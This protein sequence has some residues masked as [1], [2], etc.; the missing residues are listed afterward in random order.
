M[1][2]LSLDAGF[3]Q[4]IRQKR[5]AALIGINDLFRSVTVENLEEAIL[6]QLAAAAAEIK[7]FYSSSQTDQRIID[8]A[9]QQLINSAQTLL[10]SGTHKGSIRSIQTQINLLSSILTRILTQELESNVVTL[11][12]RGNNVSGQE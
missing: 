1:L 12:M 4:T 2:R 5:I 6:N 7:D 3:S 8:H 10:K 11:S 9:A